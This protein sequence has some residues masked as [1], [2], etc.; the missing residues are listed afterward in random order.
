M[1]SQSTKNSARWS[2]DKPFNQLPPMPADDVL[3]TDA[4][5]AGAENALTALTEARTMTATKVERRTTWRTVPLMEA[6]ASSQIENVLTTPGRMLELRSPDYENNDWATASTIRLQGQV[7]NL[8]LNDSEW[9][10]TEAAKKICSE[11]KGRE[12]PL[13][14]EPGTVI[15]GPR[16]VVY[17][18]PDEPNVIRNALRDLWEQ[19]LEPC[20]P[21]IRLIRMAAGHYQFEAI[22]TQPADPANPAGVLP[23]PQQRASGDGLG[24]V[25]ALHAAGHRAEHTLVHRPVGRIGRTSGPNRRPEPTDPHVEHQAAG[26]RRSGHKAHLDDQPRARV[27]RVL[28]EDRPSVAIPAEAGKR[29]PSQAG[30]VHHQKPVSRDTNRTHMDRPVTR[31]TRTAERK[32]CHENQNRYGSRRRGTAGTTRTSSTPYGSTRPMNRAAGVEPSTAR[33]SSKRQVR[34]GQAPSRSGT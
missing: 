28:R 24:A 14:E 34:R 7:L 30:G 5:V 15:V 20:E 2:A 12:M 13:R 22:H 21:T 16:G 25:D 29:R 26:R 11:T 9:A 27:A 31:Q 6:W 3:C 1:Q 18:P 23:A 19:L 10:S 8:W 17:T 4:A 33:R 32:L